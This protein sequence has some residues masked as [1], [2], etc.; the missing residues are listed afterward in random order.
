MNFENK[1]RKKNEKFT[2][3][4]TKIRT[5][6]NI[7][8][9]EKK[10]KDLIPLLNRL[11]FNLALKERERKRILEGKGF[12]Y[13]LCPDEVYVPAALLLQQSREQKKKVEPTDLLTK[14]DNVCV[15]SLWKPTSE[16]SHDKPPPSPYTWSSWKEKVASDDADSPMMMTLKKALEK[17]H[18]S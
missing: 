5:E 17:Y 7:K 15:T 11:E 14:V 2:S 3:Q 13:D 16:S 12:E 6:K 8:K 4:K 9:R 18:H 1:E 10:W